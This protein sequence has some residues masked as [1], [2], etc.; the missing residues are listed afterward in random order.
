MM[1][2]S[3]LRSGARRRGFTVLEILVVLAIIGLMLGLVVTNTDKLFGQGQ[4]RRDRG[5]RP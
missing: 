5:E 3:L 4:R 1:R 2:S